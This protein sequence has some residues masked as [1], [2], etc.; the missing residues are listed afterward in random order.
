MSRATLSI[1]LDTRRAKQSEGIPIYPVK[2]RVC[3]LRKAK[4]YRLG[5][6][7]T[8]EEFERSYMADR[9]R[10]EFKDLKARISNHLSKAEL[11]AQDLPDFDFVKFEKKLFRP[12][13]AGSNVFYYYQRKIEE[14]RTQD[15]IKTASSYDLSEKAIKNYLK[16]KGANTDYLSF[17]SVNGKFLNGFEKWMV[18]KQKCSLTSVGFYLRAL[19]SLFNQAIDEGEITKENYPFRKGSYEV[20]AS[21]NI[22][23][24]LSKTDLKKLY[25]FQ[26]PKGSLM[27]KAKHFFFFSYQANGMNMRDICELK[28]RDIGSGNIT[29]IRSKTK[30]TTKSK[31][32]TIVVPLTGFLRAMIEKYGNKNR[33]PDTYVFPVLKASM[34]ATERIRAVDAFTRSINTGIKKLAKGAGVDEDISTYYARHS[35]ATVAVQNGASLEFIQGSLGHSSINT[36]MNYWKGFDDTTRKQIADKLMDF[37]K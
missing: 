10:N 29:F 35:F 17:D 34:N 27:E 9:P 22:K 23:K 25:E 13:G 5:I 16:S 15:R 1:Y 19:R 24:A 36:T 6:D 30:L 32:Q 33:N 28:Y 26:P 31:Q 3:Y 37:S 18:D 14:L 12:T 21:R 7:L 11:V 4:F 2:L 20:P 8:K